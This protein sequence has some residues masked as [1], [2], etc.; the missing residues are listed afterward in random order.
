M[1]I[2]GSR[3]PGTSPRLQPKLWIDWERAHES[4]LCVEKAAVVLEPSVAKKPGQHGQRT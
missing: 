4:T 1:M 2:S 3:P